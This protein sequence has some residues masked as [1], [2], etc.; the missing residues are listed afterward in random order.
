M[1]I[2]HQPSNKPFNV[3]LLSV[4]GELSKG[5]K[6][7]GVNGAMPIKQALQ[8]LLLG[9]NLKATRKNNG[10]YTISASASASAQHVGTLAV[11]Q[12]LDAKSEEEKTRYTA[13]SMNS[14]T[15]L[16]LSLRETP[17]SVVARSI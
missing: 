11:T 14:A 2:V 16:S 13:D 7:K 15:G 10:S 8:Q 9:T 17:Q 12:V 6:S 1:A 5:K 3:I 4:S